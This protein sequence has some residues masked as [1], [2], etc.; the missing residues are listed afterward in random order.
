MSFLSHLKASRILYNNPRKASLS[1]VDIRRRNNGRQL[2][3]STVSVNEVASFATS[4]R[5]PSDCPPTRSKS[6]A[7]SVRG[8]LARTRQPTLAR[9]GSSRIS[10]VRNQEKNGMIRAELQAQTTALLETPMGAW[11][12]SQW[13]ESV[14]LIHRWTDRNPEKTFR[15]RGVG[16][17]P[18]IEMQD[19]DN[20]ILVSGTAESVLSAFSLLERLLV[21]YRRNPSEPL[22]HELIRSDLLDV[23]VI[24]WAF[25]WEQ[26]HSKEESEVSSDDAEQMAKIL[27]S[28]NAESILARM[29][30]Y[31]VRS[32][33]LLTPSI[34][35]YHRLVTAASASGTKN[36][37]IKV[38]DRLARNFNGNNFNTT[39]NETK[40]FNEPE[41]FLPEQTST[42][43]FCLDNST[44]LSRSTYLKF[45]R[46]CARMDDAAQA[47]ACLEHMYEQSVRTGLESLQ[48]TTKDFNAVLLAW[49]AHLGDL[50]YASERSRRILSRMD[51]L[52]QPG[53]ALEGKVKPDYFSYSLVMK[54]LSKWLS[55]VLNATLDNVAEYHSVGEIAE[56]LLKDMEERYRDDERKLRPNIGA[57]NSALRVLSQLGHAE[58]AEAVLQ[59]MYE[60]FTVNNNL[61]AKP[62]TASFNF[63]LTAWRNKQKTMRAST[64]VFNS[65]G[66]LPSVAIGERSEA[67]LK[68]MQELHRSG[69][70]LGVKPSS[71]SYLAVLHCWADTRSDEAGERALAILEEAKS[72]ERASGEKILNPIFYRG[73]IQAFATAGDAINAER[74]IAE[75]HRQYHE[76][77]NLDAKVG[78]N[79]VKFDFQCPP[80]LSSS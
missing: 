80:S 60:D 53:G 34:F 32:Q 23:C 63:V 54:S 16:M 45:I 31:Q 79:F 58:R 56:K 14:Q 37:C 77:G 26:M 74:V 47:E 71:A 62:E 43:D 6:R 7:P 44:D 25:C 52:S 65:K 38:L 22:A 18:P 67:I 15:R 72:M 68:R 28:Y 75:F 57:Y 66:H 61:L 8:R 24:D 33:G 10:A 3:P 41:S 13:R 48:P 20:P 29:D 50:R 70:L 27:L 9:T 59:R 12:P 4:P 30:T 17:K 49:S 1:T 19:E 5:S 35:T 40:D 76:D 46:T 11:T 2:L 42:K 21:E 73:V 55:A 39:T 36:F 64:N 78:E 51:E 69:S